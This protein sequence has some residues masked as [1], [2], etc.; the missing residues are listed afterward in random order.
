MAALLSQLHDDV[1]SRPG[2]TD[3]QRALICEKLA[4]VRARAGADS[5]LSCSA[6]RRFPIDPYPLFGLGPTSD[7]LPLNSPLSLQFPQLLRSV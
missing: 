2:L 7:R 3:L 4:Q 6:P 1:V 5:P